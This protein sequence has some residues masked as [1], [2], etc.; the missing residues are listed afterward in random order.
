MDLR[1]MSRRQLEAYSSITRVPRYQI[2][3]FED[4]FLERL[5]EEAGRAKA[6]GTEFNPTKAGLPK[7]KVY[8]SMDD[9]RWYCV[10]TSR[11]YLANAEAKSAMEAVTF[12]E[13]GNVDGA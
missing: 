2:E 7:F 1:S 8:A 13:Y 4:F 12:L 9:G 10:D 5:D 11:G 6:A 3:D